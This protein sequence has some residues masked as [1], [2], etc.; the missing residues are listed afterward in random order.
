MTRTDVDAREARDKAVTHTASGDIDAVANGNLFKVPAGDAGATVHVGASAFHLDGDQVRRGIETSNSLGRTTGNASLNVDLPISR[1]NTG[2]DKLGNLT[3]NANA[4]VEQLS[5]FGTLTTLGAGAN[6]SPVKRLNLIGSWN[7]RERGSFGCPQLGNPILTTPDTRTSISPPANL[8]VTAVTVE[9]QIS[10]PTGATCSSSAG[11]RSLSRIPIFGFAPTM[12]HLRID[13]PVSIFPDQPHPRSGLSGALRSRCR[14]QS[15]QRR[16]SARQLRQFAAPKRLGSAS[17]SPSRSNPPATIAG[18]HRSVPNSPGGRIR[19]TRKRA[20]RRGQP[21]GTPGRWRGIESTSGWR[22]L[23]RPRLWRSAEAATEAASNFL[24]DRYDHARGRRHDP[25]RL[26]ARLSGRRR[27][28]PAGSRATR[29]R[30]RPVISTTASE[31][32]SPPIGE[33]GRASSP[34]RVTTFA[35]RRSARSTSGCSPTSASGSV[36][37]RRSIPGFAEPRSSSK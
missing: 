14:G 31:R 11:T 12:S 35:S 32:G 29:S 23:W 24:A 16:P 13:N 2:F 36:A 30:H 18:R 9:L 33:A 4:K 20:R 1:R 34:R 27:G 19:E 15:C 21:A 7:S 8:L 5:D 25:R 17:T 28:P 10:S 26:E 6:W 3:L 37:C 22:R